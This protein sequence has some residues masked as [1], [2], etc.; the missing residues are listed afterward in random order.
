MAG[1]IAYKVLAEFNFDITGAIASSDTLQNS[2]GKV[3]DMADS[4]LHKLEAIPRFLI[5]SLGIN[6][7]LV[8]IFAGAV[9]SVENLN[10]QTLQFSNIISGN[11]DKLTGPIDTFNDRMVYSKQLLGEMADKA[12]EFSIDERAFISMTKLMSAQLIPKGL[13]GVNMNTAQEM[14]RGL[15]KSAPV[16]GVDPNLVQNDL[17]RAIEGSAS[18][19]DTVFRRLA[20]ETKVFQTLRTGGPGK[21]GE[22]MSD[23]RAFPKATSTTP[24]SKLFNSLPAPE[25]V[26]MLTQALTQFGDDADVVAGNAKLLSNMMLVFRNRIFGIRGVLQPLGEVL[27]PRLVK[28][29][30]ILTSA[31]DSHVRPVVE[32]FALLVDSLLANPERVFATLTQLRALKGDLMF[33]SKALPI[34]EVI[35]HMG[36]LGLVLGKFPAIIM[37]ASAALSAMMT[38]LGLGVAT[39]FIAAASASMAKGTATVAAKISTGGIM[40]T[41]FS[42]IITAFKSFISNFIPIVTFIGKALFYISKLFLIPLAIFTTI[43]QILSR[44]SGFGKVMD[45]KAIVNPA[46]KVAESIAKVSEAFLQAIKPFDD[47]MNDIAGFLAPVFSYE[48][49]LGPISML[50]S[51]LTWVLEV[52]RDRLVDML[53]GFRGLSFFVIHVFGNMFNEIGTMLNNVLFNTKHFTDVFMTFFLNLYGVVENSLTGFGMMIEK[54]F[55]ELLEGNFKTAFAS[56]GQA[57]QDELAKIAVAQPGRVFKEGG[58]SMKT[59]GADTNWNQVFDGGWQE[60]KNGMKSTYDQYN[61]V[62]ASKVTGKRDVSNAGTTIGKV[63]IRNE[64]REQME[65]DRIANSLVKTLMEVAENPRQAKGQSMNAGFFR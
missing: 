60:F 1:S 38:K 43:M 4:I 59:I 55:E 16:L 58:Q 21:P 41:V 46:N 27:V 22:R 18:M 12:A 8:G 34:V 28:A 6:F 51:G 9:A 39:P 47:F 48:L 62:Y 3:S 29:M 11:M 63:E 14:S 30:Q 32:R 36:F 19:N 15:L 17:L 33:I 53:S 26:K 20:A 44:A 5:S 7:S 23:G 35:A 45:A 10:A 13:A 57:L 56:A 52:F 37:K 64:F 25:R 40:G 2:L 31:I 61:D 65:P 54:L 49:W 24:L 50:L 42:G